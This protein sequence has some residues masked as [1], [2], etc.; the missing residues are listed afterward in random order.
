MLILACHLV[1]TR[2]FRQQEKSIRALRQ[3][4]WQHDSLY[5]MM[6]QE[7][8]FDEMQVETGLIE[9]SRGEYKLKSKQ[10]KV[11]ICQRRFFQ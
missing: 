2:S 10:R 3:G 4:S 7:R 11:P 5:L 9:F 8:R 1:V 6:K